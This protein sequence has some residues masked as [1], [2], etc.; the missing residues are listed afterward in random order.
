MTSANKSTKYAFQESYKSIYSKKLGGYL[1][2]SENEYVK[3]LDRLKIPK[4]LVSE[5]V[6]SSLQKFVKENLMNINWY[7][8]KIENERKIKNRYLLG[9]VFLL[10]LIPIIVFSLTDAFD[11]VGQESVDQAKYVT[12]LL[13]VILTIVF[14][15][16]KLVNSWYEQRDFIGQFHGALIDLKNIVYEFEEDWIENLVKDENGIETINP[17]FL[18]AL[19]EQTEASRLIVQTETKAYFQKLSKPNKIDLSSILTTSKDTA[20]KVF[21]AL[22]SSNFDI[23]NAEDKLKTQTEKKIKAENNSKNIKKNE[24]LLVEIRKAIDVKANEISTLDPKE[25]KERISSLKISLKSLQTHFDKVELKVI[26]GK[27]TANS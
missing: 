6:K 24:A 11:L 20:S 23:K 25:D 27:V 21:E 1:S 9:N 10:L 18:V 8:K 15:I 17:D 16:N 2:F 12:S 13:T 19:M 3:L 22:K 14:G 26:E 5:N 4:S 7:S